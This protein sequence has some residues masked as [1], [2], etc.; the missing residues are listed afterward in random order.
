MAGFAV[1]DIG[2]NSIRYAEEREGRLRGK[3][4]IT[5]RLGSG[6]SKTG[7]LAP[8]T[9]ERSLCVLRGLAE[10][11]RAKGLAPRAYATSAVR[12]AENGREFAERVGRECGCP[13]EI[14][15][16]GEE[17]RYAF[18]GASSGGRAFDGM[19]DIGGAS[20]QIVTEDHAVSFPAGCVRC[21]DI[22]RE[23]ANAPDCDY[24]WKLQRE[25]VRGYIARL[26]E[27]YDPPRIRR[28]VGV[29]GTITTLAALETGL[30]AFDV[31]AVESRVLTRESV[32]AMISRLAEMGG[33]RRLHP[34]LRERHDVILY[35]AYILA[36]ALELI[37]AE[38]MG[39]SCSD[40]MEGYLSILKQR[41]AEHGND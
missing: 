37:G 5:T 13:V 30:E 33:G 32:E 24:A 41:E 4:V 6:L 11:A 10:E 34:L 2:S 35:G 39:V 14:L 26:T 20:M 12:D 29:G 21:A 9:M 23:A 19:L 18:L 8:E 28:L 27:G 17:A 25:A 1:I 16:G 40:G 38:R 7:R 3:R 22:A 15:T 31:Q 36:C